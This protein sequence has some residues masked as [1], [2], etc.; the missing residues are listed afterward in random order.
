[1]AR[2]HLAGYQIKES[3]GSRRGQRWGSASG[4]SIKN[5]GQVTYRFATESG[6]INKGTTHGG[7]V[8]RPLAAVSRIT[9]ANNICFLSEG[10][11]W[12]IDRRDP[13]AAELLKLVEKAKMRTKM[14][15]HRGTY[16]IRAWILPEGA[17]VDK[18]GSP[19]PF[20]R[21]GR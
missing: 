20:G 9:K 19:G 18:E 16:R 8:R 11:D 15:Q 2:R 13:V 4:H 1:M 5:E 3:E 21:P 7:E 12:I 14:Y 6:D 10:S 17:K